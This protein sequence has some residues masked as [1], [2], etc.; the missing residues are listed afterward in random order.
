MRGNLY[1]ALLALAACVCKYSMC[2]C[3]VIH[4]CAARWVTISRSAS[5]STMKFV[6]LIE[7]ICRAVRSSGRCPWDAAVLKVATQLQGSPEQYILCWHFCKSYEVVLE[8][9]KLAVGG[10]LS[11]DFLFKCSR[12]L[13]LSGS[14]GKSGTSRDGV[15]VSG[16][17]ICWARPV[18]SAWS[19][20]VRSRPADR[21]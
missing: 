13:T 4:W 19:A 18:F 9:G 7:S 5:F 8:A 15:A 20:A 3:R 6:A 2:R 12:P 16:R 11:C 1:S 14:S 10:F 21:A 17:V